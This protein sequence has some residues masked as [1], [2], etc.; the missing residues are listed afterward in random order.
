M[1]A[2]GLPIE[3]SNN[4]VTT[5]A[6]LNQKEYLKMSSTCQ[7]KEKINHAIHTLLKNCPL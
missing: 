5:A 3:S 6:W 4:L 1:S 7:N 2:V